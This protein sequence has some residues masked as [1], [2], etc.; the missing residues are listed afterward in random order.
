MN[1]NEKTYLVTAN[2]GTYAAAAD[3]GQLANVGAAIAARVRNGKTL[4]LRSAHGCG[5]G[6]DT[7]GNDIFFG[8]MTVSSDS[9]TFSLTNVD[10]STEVGDF[11]RAEGVAALVTVTES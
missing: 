2:F 7:V 11:T 5:P 4:T 10:R 1:G 9:L 6:V 8:A 3:S